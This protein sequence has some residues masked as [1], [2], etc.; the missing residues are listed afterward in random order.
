MNCTA[1]LKGVILEILQVFKCI[2]FLSNIEGQHLQIFVFNQGY[3]MKPEDFCFPHITR[4]FSDINAFR[5]AYTVSCLV[6]IPFLLTS[7]VGNFT[8]LFCLWKCRSLHPPFKALLRGLVLSDLGV[9]SIV[10]PLFLAS[11]YM[12]LTGNMSYFCV[13]NVVYNTIG[14]FLAAVSFVTTTSIALDRFFAI[15]LRIRYR[16]FA[17]LRKTYSLVAFIWVL[18][19]FLSSVWI[20]NVALHRL[21]RDTLLISCI[22]I[23]CVSY[24]RVFMLVRQCQVGL[25]ANQV[26]GN[27]AFHLGRYKKTV[28]STVYVFGFLLLC[29][30]P[31]LC[32]S[33]AA[34]RFEQNTTL[35]LSVHIALVLVLA[36]SSF[37]PALYCWRIPEI[38]QIAKESF[39]KLFCEIL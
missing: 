4:A 6:A 33:V 30:M 29:Y 36:N 17:T 32:L 26:Q 19:A 1:N 11:N 9:G 5:T 25:N 8:M 28:A 31:Y 34:Q 12:A 37:N 22:T 23:A 35:S 16:Q 2:F 24:I 14:Y 20:W 27:G 39:G 13:I 18:C 3:K 7:I 15:Q 38:R 10:Q 21:F